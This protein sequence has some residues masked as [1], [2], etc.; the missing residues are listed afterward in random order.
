MFNGINQAASSTLPYNSNPGMDVDQMM[1]LFYG[2]NSYHTV[3]DPWDNYHE[4]ID[5]WAKF[6]SHEK[7]IICQVPASHFRYAEIE[8]VVNYYENQLNSYGE[9]YEIYRVYTPQNQP[10]TNSI[11]LNSKVL[12]PITGSSWDDDAIDI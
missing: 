7:I 8:N 11:I 5:C 10:Y 2:V 3:D 6:L 9:H 4:H 1:F 12:V